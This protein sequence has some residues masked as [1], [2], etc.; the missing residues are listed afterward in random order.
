MIRYDISS[1]PTIYIGSSLSF[2][3]RCNSLV[4]VLYYSYMSSISLCL[5]LAIHYNNDMY[6]KYGDSVEPVPHA[7]AGN[8]YASISSSSSLS[9]GARRDITAVLVG[10]MV[11]VRVWVIFIIDCFIYRHYQNGPSNYYW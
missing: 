8:N 2:C 4:Y 11:V 9:T 7:T 3:C 5:R 10:R 1:Y 6:N